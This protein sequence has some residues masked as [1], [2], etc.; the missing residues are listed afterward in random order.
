MKYAP[1]L[2]YVD[3]REL[4]FRLGNLGAALVG[5]L[6][7]ITSCAIK[8]P[9]AAYF[10]LAGCYLS[11][12]GYMHALGYRYI[13]VRDAFACAALAY[14]KVFELRGTEEGIDKH[15]AV[16]D[17]RYPPPGRTTACSTPP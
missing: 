4:E 15:V 13:D 8:R 11:I 14:L 17:T 1:R 10:M 2:D 16:F 3:T 9:Q 7:Q 5:D 6:A 12:G